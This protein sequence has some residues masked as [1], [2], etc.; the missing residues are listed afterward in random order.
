MSA[1]VGTAFQFNFKIGNDLHNIYAENGQEAIDQLT[2]FES[3]I[4]PVLTSVSQKIGGVAAVVPSLPVA[5]AAQQGYTAAA[6]TADAGN[7]GAPL[8]D[9]GLPMKLIPAGISKASGKPYKAFWVCDQPRGMQCDKKVT[10]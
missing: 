8:C 9:H 1:Q 3:D 5:P 10:T 7:A 6:S 4:L 2:F